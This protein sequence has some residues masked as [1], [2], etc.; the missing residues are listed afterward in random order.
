MN[1]SDL[2]SVCRKP[3]SKEQKK[4]HNRTCSPGCFMSSLMAPV[5]GDSHA[6]TPVN[7]TVTYPCKAWEFQYWGPVEGPSQNVTSYVPWSDECDE[8][9]T[10]WVDGDSYAGDFNTCMGSS[11]SDGYLMEVSV[12]PSEHGYVY[13]TVY[14]AKT[15]YGF[16]K[17]GHRP[18]TQRLA[19]SNSLVGYGWTEHQEDGPGSKPKRWQ[20]TNYYVDFDRMTMHFKERDE[21]I[22]SY[23]DFGY[24][25]GDDIKECGK[26]HS[27][28]V[29][30]FD[31]PDSFFFVMTGYYVDGLHLW[32]HDK[33]V[34]KR[35]SY[36]QRHLEYVKHQKLRREKK[37]IHLYSY[38]G[39]KFKSPVSV[40]RRRR[41]L[42]YFKHQVVSLYARGPRHGE[43]TG[44]FKEEF[45]MDLRFDFMSDERSELLKFGRI[46]RRKKRMAVK[47]SN[48]AFAT[49]YDPWHCET[50]IIS[51][52]PRWNGV[53]IRDNIFDAGLEIDLF[54]GHYPMARKPKDPESEDISDFIGREYGKIGKGSRKKINR[55]QKWN[56]TKKR[57]DERHPGRFRWFASLE[58]GYF[59]PSVL[60]YF[61]G[62]PTYHCVNSV[63]SVVEDKQPTI[64]SKRSSLVFEDGNMI[65]EWFHQWLD[66]QGL[67]RP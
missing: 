3:L 34:E 53:V 42:I 21:V 17:S 38:D 27:K 26:M 67:S 51:E 5:S 37:G 31:I 55:F 44:F 59:S 22:K 50:I 10:T 8:T 52:N 45:P 41:S 29:V 65:C 58:H 25:Y 66:E 1:D 40:S 18:L 36:Q 19:K 30:G 64:S 23:R 62:F 43:I 28:D 48:L 54:V 39:K 61:L 24:R 56:Y 32:S 60:C 57:R 47:H 20:F 35:M 6:A 7:E 15:D 46:G 49:V 12:Q 4:H 9:V 33:W 13:S 63:Y 16:S 14:D 2:C 11:S